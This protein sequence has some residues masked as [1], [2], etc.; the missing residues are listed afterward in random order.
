MAGHFC[1]AWQDRTGHGH[2]DST[3]RKQQVR[4]HRKLALSRTLGRQFWVKFSWLLTGCVP[5]CATHLY[6]H[7]RYSLLR[8]WSLIKTQKHSFP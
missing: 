3:W 4:E 5:K 6:T 1:N 7:S 8:A 2:W